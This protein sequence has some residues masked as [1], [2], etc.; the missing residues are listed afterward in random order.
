MTAN[1]ADELPIP[2]MAGVTCTF[3][4]APNSR[5]LNGSIQPSLPFDDPLLALVRAHANQFRPGF[6]TWISENR[7]VYTAFAREADR[8]WQRGRRH[9][10]ARTIGEVLRHES[11]LAEK[12]SEW[13]LNNCVFPDLA[14]LYVIA[15]PARAGF[16]EFRVMPGSERAA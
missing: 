11:A 14:R 7:H 15:N 1:S 6:L 4:A 3:S 2:T 12:D 16:F 8:I 13:K 5:G 9:Y 10:S